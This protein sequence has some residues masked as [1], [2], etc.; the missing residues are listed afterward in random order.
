MENDKITLTVNGKDFKGRRSRGR[1]GRRFSRS[2][3]PTGSTCRRSAT[4]PRCP[5]TADAGFVSWKSRTCAGCPPSCTTPATDG[6]VVHT[7]TQ[8]VI[9]VR[10]TVLELLLAYGKHDC[11]L[12]EK[13]GKCELERL[14]YEHGIQQVRYKTD[15][16][17]ETCGRRQRHDCP[18]PEQV[19][20]VR[21][22]RS[23]LPQCSGERGDRRGGPRSDSFITTF[24]ATSLKDSNCVFCGQCVQSCPVGALTEKMA[25]GRGR[26][27]EMKKVTTHLYLL[28]RGVPA[29]I[30][31]EGQQSCQG[32]IES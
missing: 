7:H 18:G 24:N 10:K 5:L 12:C 13:L 20:A 1:R 21:T 29:R 2:S 25:K 8:K 30:E 4:T 9:D 3:G 27:W 6:M 23:G 15:F 17:T 19:R 22:L 31:R 11:I 14:V 16:C 26:T 28:R 32:H